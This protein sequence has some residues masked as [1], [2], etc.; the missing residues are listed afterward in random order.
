MQQLKPRTKFYS[1]GIVYQQFLRDVL[2]REALREAVGR[3]ADVEL[4][5]IR[6]A[7]AC[8]VIDALFGAGGA[9]SPDGGPPLGVP[10]PRPRVPAARRWGGVEVFDCDQQ[11]R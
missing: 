1:C 3:L 10:P 8:D 9:T 6:E 5:R 4:V 2:A 7:E 11:A